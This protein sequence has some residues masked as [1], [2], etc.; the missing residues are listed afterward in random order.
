[1]RNASK[2]N[3]LN[4]C[5]GT[6]LEWSRLLAQESTNSKTGDNRNEC[7]LIALEYF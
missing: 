7:N 6:N 3:D 1:M 4:E 5:V 2:G